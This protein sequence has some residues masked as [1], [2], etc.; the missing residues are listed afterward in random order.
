MPSKLPQ[1]TLRIPQEQMYKF[2]YVAEYNARSCNR[3]L[4]Q[5]IKIH[6]TKFEKEHGK[7]TEEDIKSLK[8][9]NDLIV[10]IYL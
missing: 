3:E 8:K 6:I 5:L 9:I 2:R 10:C 7:I 1:F 4:E